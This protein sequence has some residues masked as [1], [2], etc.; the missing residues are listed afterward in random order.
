MPRVVEEVL[1]SAMEDF[2]L[3]IIIGNDGSSRSIKIDLPPFTL[4]G[5]TTRVGDL[6]S[7][8]RDRFG[9]ISKLEYYTIEDL[10]NIIKKTAVIPVLISTMFPVLHKPYL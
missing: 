10:C 8:L 6:T 7:P 3:D 2:T 9:I 4:V 1:Y 5:A